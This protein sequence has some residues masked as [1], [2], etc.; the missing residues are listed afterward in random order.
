AL[1]LTTKQDIIK[2]ENN[3]GGGNHVAGDVDWDADGNL[4]L[5]TGD[6]TGAGAGNA[7]G[8]A[9]IND[10][11]GQNPAN[12]T[13]RGA[14]NPND[15]RGKILRIKVQA[16]GSY[17]IPPGN[18]FAPG[19]MG[20]RPEVYVMGLRN[21]FRMNVDRKTGTLVWGDYGPDAGRDDV[22]RGP[23]GV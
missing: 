4:Y 5:A 10:S 23:M 6:N 20:T 7:N 11:A 3:R 21:P 18:L 1:D 16:D 17:T 2:V 13:R 14:G 19:T 12:D 22:T 15:L 8:Y 9:P